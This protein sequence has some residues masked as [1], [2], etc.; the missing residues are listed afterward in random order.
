[1]RN[2]CITN[3]FFEGKP[4]HH[5]SYKHPQSHRGR[6]LGCPI[7][8]TLSPAF[9][10]YPLPPYYAIWHATYAQAWF[11][12]VT[13]R[14]RSLPNV[15]STLS[16]HSADCDTD[17]TLV[18]SRVR[19]QPKKLKT[20]SPHKQCQDC[21]LWA[22][23]QIPGGPRESLEHPWAKMPLPDGTSRG[24]PS[25]LRPC[26][27]SAER[28][29]PVTTGLTPVHRSWSPFLRSN[30]KPSWT[31]KRTTWENS[32]NTPRCPQCNSEHCQTLD[33]LWPLKPLFENDEC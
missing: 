21:W 2:L 15:L 30:D 27:P 7:R 28:R 22:S 8:P 16:Y 12:Q 32:N 13:T 29:G 31:S 17:H 24:R 33:S 11:D 10:L 26:Q 5:V 25:S 14:R 3:T 1:M 4:Q 19:L 6:Q 18:Y 20:S 23:A 9:S